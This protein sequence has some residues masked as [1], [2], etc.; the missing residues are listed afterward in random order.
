ML[1]QT[2]GILRKS[3]LIVI[4]ANVWL[5]QSVMAQPASLGYVD[6]V[7]FDFYGHYVYG[8]A[9]MEGVAESV[10]VHVYIGGY[11]GNWGALLANGVADLSSEQAVADVCDSGYYYH[12]FEV[13]I[14][15]I[16]RF[17]GQSIW[18][19]GINTQGGISVPIT[20]SGD[21][22]VPYPT[23]TLSTPTGFDMNENYIGGGIVQRTLTWNSVSGAND[24][25]ISRLRGDTAAHNEVFTSSTGYV[26]NEVVGYPYRYMVAACYSASVSACGVYSDG[27]F[28]D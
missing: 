18:V 9:C 8:W 16:K 3:I 27:E 14:E 10:D 1:N 4:F 7:D 6:G 19:H 25:V 15:N 12:R 20:N 21:Y 22:D 26:F 5:N 24:Y 23:G 11:A 17:A 28:A 13:S 2:L